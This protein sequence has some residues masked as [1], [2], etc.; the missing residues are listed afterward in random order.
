M[1]TVR[2][3]DTGLLTFRQGVY[4]TSA[5]IMMGCT[6]LMV[7]IAARAAHQM[8]ML[9]N[10]SAHSLGLCPHLIKTMP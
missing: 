10:N 7:S 5:I 4:F 9:M 8:A 2:S 1:Y 6:Y 3:L